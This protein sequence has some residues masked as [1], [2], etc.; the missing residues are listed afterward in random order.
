MSSATGLKSDSWMKVN[1]V[2][3][4]RKSVHLDPGILF[5]LI[6][7]PRSPWP[8]IRTCITDTSGAA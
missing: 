1:A 8:G 7:E 3:G 6:L 4:L 2:P 5:T